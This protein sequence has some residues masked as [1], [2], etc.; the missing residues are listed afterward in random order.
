MW[1]LLS[2]IFELFELSFITSSTNEVWKEIN[3]IGA[4]EKSPELLLRFRRFVD[5]FDITCY[6][7]EEL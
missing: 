7:V 3:D 4:R 1:L 5:N 2:K 6:I